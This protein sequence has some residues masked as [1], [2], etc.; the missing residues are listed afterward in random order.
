MDKVASSLLATKTVGEK[1]SVFKTKSIALTLDRQVPSKIG[2]KTLG[3]DDSESARV[4]LPQAA[5]LFGQK[6]ASLP[7]VDSLVS[8]II[9]GFS[10]FCHSVRQ[11]IV[12]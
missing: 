12:F 3:N 4:A 5:T 6:A 1:P 2:G 8:A 7:L 9:S 10:L 11:S